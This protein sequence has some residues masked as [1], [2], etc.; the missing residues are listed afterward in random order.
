MSTYFVWTL[1]Q[2]T[3][4]NNQVATKNQ[5]EIDQL[6]ESINIT[7]GPSYVLDYGGKTVTVAFTAQNDGAIS[8]NLTTLWI[9]GVNL[10]GSKL[11]DSTP[12][13]TGADRGIKLMPGN[14]TIPQISQQFSFPSLDSSY[15]SNNFTGWMITERGRI[16]MLYPA[17]QQGPAGAPGTNG[18]Q[19]PAG[20]KGD[21]G[22]TGATGPA[23]TQGPT[24]SPGPAGRNFNDTGNIFLYNG[25]D[26]DTSTNAY[27]AQGIGSL[28]FDFN[29]FAYY[30]V[31]AGTKKVSP[32]PT[33]TQSYTIPVASNIAYSINITNFNPQ[34]YNI[35][36]AG[37]CLMW[38]Y[39]PFVPGHTLGPTWKLTN[40]STDTLNYLT[41]TPIT[42]EY[43]K[44][45][46]IYFAQQDT[47]PDNSQKNNLAAINLLFFGNYTT[48]NLGVTTTIK[49][50]GQNI[51]FV[52]LYFTS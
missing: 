36:L 49:S 34:K 4:Y 8:V 24:G 42:L 52:S 13:M 22:L 3:L 26:S 48:T 46:T 11:A 33:G 12:L 50:Y 14:L 21:T 31:N 28:S 51:P 27:V 43:G 20:A 18:Q 7:S 45:T 9:Q 6:T 1:G 35:T 30:S 2:N 32:Y 37:N 40:N 25:T 16:I 47:A 5:L 29:T 39:F 17:H 10:L 44:P 19:G 23:G 38:S 41:Y 15:Y